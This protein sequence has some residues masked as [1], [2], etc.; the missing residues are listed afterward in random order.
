MS[1]NTR[2]Y[3][4]QKT[5]VSGFDSYSKIDDVKYLKS[6]DTIGNTSIY[7]PD[8]SKDNKAG[9]GWATTRYLDPNFSSFAIT[10]SPSSEYT[11]KIP[12]N[13]RRIKNAYVMYSLTAASST[14]ACGIPFQYIKMQI[15]EIDLPEFRREHLIFVNTAFEGNSE[16]FTHTASLKGYSS[17]LA[18]DATSTSAEVR[19]IDISPMIP[20]DFHT[21][22]TG[23]DCYFKYTF[24]IINNCV[25]SGG[26]ITVSSLYFIFT[27]WM[28]DDAQWKMFKA[29]TK[30]GVRMIPYIYPFRVD[31]GSVTSSSSASTTLVINQ[32]KGRTPFFFVGLYD[33]GATINQNGHIYVQQ[34]SCGFLDSSDNNL[35]VNFDMNLSE[36]IL[37]AQKHGLSNGLHPYITKSMPFI[38]CKDL[39]GTIFNHLNTGGFPMKISEE[40]IKILPSTTATTAFSAH[41]IGFYYCFLTMSPDGHLIGSPRIVE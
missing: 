24:D 31:L 11:F 14:P 38:F 37:L 18:S 35:V 32:L 40:K 17:A 29:Q 21:L 4:S 30:L 10:T 12:Q 3:Y 8:I 25:T 2:Q 20:R 28:D 39:Y 9:Y 34:T 26:S 22:E 36:S 41:V 13:L 5:S 27:E 33:S 6:P 23:S 16:D 15:G 19:M 1:G 7:V